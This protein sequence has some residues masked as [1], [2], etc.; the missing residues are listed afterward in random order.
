MDVLRKCDR[1][2]STAAIR[3]MLNLPERTL[4]TIW[5]DKKI[6]AAFKARVGCASS[7]VSSGQS[8]FMVHLEKMLVKG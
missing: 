8:T 5:K 6:T 1:G 2:E 4:H 7:R 3:N